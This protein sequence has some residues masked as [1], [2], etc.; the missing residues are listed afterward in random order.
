MKAALANSLSIQEFI[1]GNVCLKAVAKSSEASFCST[2]DDF[3]S[4]DDSAE[5]IAT[6]EETTVLNK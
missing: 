4:Y 3:Q 5:A 2:S 6:K 1:L